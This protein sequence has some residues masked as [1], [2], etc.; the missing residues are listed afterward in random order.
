MHNIT[1]IVALLRQAHQALP[2]PKAIVQHF[3][4]PRPEPPFGYRTLHLSCE[5]WERSRT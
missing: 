4:M 3:R 1:E 2:G 5:M